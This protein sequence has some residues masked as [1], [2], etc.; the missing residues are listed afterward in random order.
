MKRDWLRVLG[1]LDPAEATRLLHVA[2]RN[3]VARWR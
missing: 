2:V 3:S 1:W